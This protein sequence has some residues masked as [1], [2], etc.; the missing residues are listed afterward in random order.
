VQ[1]ATVFFIFLALITPWSYANFTVQTTQYIV[2]CWLSVCVDY[3]AAPGGFNSINSQAIDGASSRAGGVAIA[4]LIIAGIIAI[5][6][7]FMSYKHRFWT[8]VTTSATTVSILIAWASWIGVMVNQSHDVTIYSVY[9]VMK[10]PSTGAVYWVPSAGFAFTLIAQVLAII[11]NVLA[12]VAGPTDPAKPTNGATAPSQ[13][14]I[15]ANPVAISAPMP[16][17]S[18][19]PAPVAT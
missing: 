19:Q 16:V 14:V 7:I 2:N 6:S 18:E 13:V 3:I 10:F 9:N 8:I 12:V 17:S 1:A 15:A 5:V 4:F 11:V